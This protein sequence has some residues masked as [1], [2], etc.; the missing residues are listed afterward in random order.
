[1]ENTMEEQ[2]LLD[3]P[4]Y[5]QYAEGKRLIYSYT[6]LS[7]EQCELGE[8]LGRFIIDSQEN[9]S[10]D[11]ITQLKSGKAN[12]TTTLMSYLFLKEGDENIETNDKYFQDIL[13]ILRATKNNK[14]YKIFKE[15][16]KDF[17]CNIGEEWMTSLLLP[18]KLKQLKTQNTS[19]IFLA[20]MQMLGESKTNLLNGGSESKTQ[21]TTKKS[22]K[23]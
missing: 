4:I 16:T 19:K 1:M 13:K 22:E 5:F 9:L 2:K 7:I 6:Y 23:E 20:A 17:F 10:P 15:V 3:E 8:S 18:D 11:F 21:T 14:Q 12:W